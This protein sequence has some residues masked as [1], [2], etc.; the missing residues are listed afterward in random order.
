M[1]NSGRFTLGIIFIIIGGL[2]LAGQ[3]TNIDLG[4]VISVGW[5]IIIILIGIRVILKRERHQEYRYSDE[6]VNSDNLREEVSFGG[7]KKRI[8]SDKFTGGFAEVSFGELELDLSG[9]KVIEG[10]TLKVEVTFGS[11]KLFLPDDVRLVNRVDQF[12][13]DVDDRKR[14]TGSGATLVLV[15]NVSFG[16]IEIM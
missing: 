5:P 9:V 3:F 10:S 15:G 12:A 16:N 13:G 8:T 1:H 11:L 7:A 2:L 4:Q 6:T 14:N